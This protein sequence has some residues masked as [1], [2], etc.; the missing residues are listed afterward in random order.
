MKN[1]N[2]VCPYVKVFPSTVIK[3]TRADV[4]QIQTTTTTTRP[5][6]ITAA[7]AVVDRLDWVYFT[8]T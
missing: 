5:Y 7:I 1:K 3:H 8:E 6:D 2:N 4:K